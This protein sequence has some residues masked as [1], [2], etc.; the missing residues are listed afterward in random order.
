L[1]IS[2]D[3]NRKHHFVKLQYQSRWHLYHVLSLTGML[4][5]FFTCGTTPNPKPTLKN[6]WTQTRE[7]G[8]SSYSFWFIHMCRRLVPWQQL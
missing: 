4:P 2:S 5:Q 3:T 6:L 1:I 8:V 7:I